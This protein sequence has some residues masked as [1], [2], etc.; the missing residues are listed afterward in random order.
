MPAALKASDLIEA[1]AGTLGNQLPY[2]HFIVFKMLPNA[3]INMTKVK[4]FWLNLIV[5]IELF[6]KQN[7]K[8]K[9]YLLLEDET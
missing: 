1:I 5:R 8:A 2:I 3:N 4:Y 7:K 9:S 6:N